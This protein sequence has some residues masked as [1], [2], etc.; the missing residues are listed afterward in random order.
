MIEFDGPD[1]SDVPIIER[2]RAEYGDTPP[3][4]DEFV[5]RYAAL[6]AELDAKS[7]TEYFPGAS[8]D[9]ARTTESESEPV[10]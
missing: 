5:A 1:G 6:A 2:I 10:G 7:D 8:R 3:D 9:D 4:P